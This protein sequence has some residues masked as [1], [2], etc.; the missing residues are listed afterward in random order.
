MAGLYGMI[1]MPILWGTTSILLPVDCLTP[2]EVD[3]VGQV[4]KI[5]QVDGGFYTPSLLMDICVDEKALSLVRD[6]KY[7]FFSG[8]PLEKW[9]GDLLCKLTLVLPF[10]GSTETRS[11]PIYEPTGEEWRYYSFHPASGYRMEPYGDGLFE[12]VIDRKAEWEPFQ[13]VFKVFPELDTYHTKDLYSRHGLN[14]WL[15]E[16]RRIIS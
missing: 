8:A 9:V 4:L 14:R 3:H 7:V 2:V 13:F 6:Q 11:F 5:I 12:L 10:P 1:H 16:G 15:F